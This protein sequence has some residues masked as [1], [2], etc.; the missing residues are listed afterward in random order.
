MNV[1]PNWLVLVPSSFGMFEATHSSNKTKTF[2]WKSIC[3][4]ITVH[5][6]HCIF[7]KVVF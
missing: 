5:I 7:R 2:G 4:I 3:Y 6:L 1:P